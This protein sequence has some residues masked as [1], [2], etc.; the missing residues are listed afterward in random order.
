MKHWVRK[1]VSGTG[2]RARSFVE[3][4]RVLSWR[5]V[6]MFPFEERKFNY[7]FQE[8]NHFNGVAERGEYDVKVLTYNESTRKSVADLKLPAASP[9]KID[10]MARVARAIVGRLRTG[11]IGPQEVLLVNLT[12]QDMAISD[13]AKRCRKDNFFLGKNKNGNIFI[14]FTED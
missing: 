13:A 6:G 9:D 5:A 8:G 10:A 14:F 2:K 3:R 11:E 1:I 12:R 4:A 7:S